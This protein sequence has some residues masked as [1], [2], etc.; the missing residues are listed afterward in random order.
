M[1]SRKSQITNA[2]RKYRQR[3]KNEGFV[4]INSW[5]PEN[6]REHLQEISNKQ[7][8]TQDQVIVMALLA[9]SLDN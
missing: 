2:Q 7:G 9:I 3:M 4:R 8:Q 1:P 6:V 5:I